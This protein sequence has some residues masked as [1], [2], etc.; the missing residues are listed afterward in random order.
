MYEAGPFLRWKGAHTVR[1]HTGVSSAGRATS[2]GGSGRPDGL[3]TPQSQ[4]YQLTLL[5]DWQRLLPLA[6]SPVHA[7]DNHVGLKK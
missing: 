3:I 6:G 1:L 4:P 5:S 7:F 2:S